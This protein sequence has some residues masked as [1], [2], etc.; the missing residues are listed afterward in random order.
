MKK[1]ED[2]IVFS[3]INWGVR[4]IMKVRDSFDLDTFLHLCVIPSKNKAC[5]EGLIPCQLQDR[6]IYLDYEGEGLQDWNTKV[7]QVLHGKDKL[8]E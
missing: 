8:K 3:F 2:Y 1:G 6:V 7:T 5:F 4:C